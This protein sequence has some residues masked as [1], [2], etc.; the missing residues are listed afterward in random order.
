MIHD[1]DGVRDHETDG[2]AL[3]GLAWAFAIE[4]AAGVVLALALWLLG[5]FT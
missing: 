3:T 5:L 1:E 4:T 2:C